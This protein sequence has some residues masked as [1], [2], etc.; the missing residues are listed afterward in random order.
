MPDCDTCT[1]PDSSLYRLY[2]SGWSVSL[3]VFTDCSGET[4]WQITGH[5]GENLIKV[6]GVSPNEAWNKAV[7]AAAACGML[8]DWP[9]PP[10]E[11][12]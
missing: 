11:S 12:W 8:R 7:L 6:D 3:M 10:H 4:I 5:Q 9:R 2:R 1:L